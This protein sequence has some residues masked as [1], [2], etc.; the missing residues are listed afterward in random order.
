MPNSSGC[1]TGE[2]VL[3]PPHRRLAYPNCS[4]A[5]T[6]ASVTTARLTPRTR[7]AEMP[8]TR[9][10]ITAAAEPTSGPHGNPIPALAVM[11]ETANPATPASVTWASDTW[12]TNPVITT[13]ERHTTIPTIDT[14]SAW[15]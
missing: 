11:C 9:P 3:P 2:P 1:S 12:P 6:P 14:I 8:N 10:I 7:N 4:M 5:T 15:R 13:S